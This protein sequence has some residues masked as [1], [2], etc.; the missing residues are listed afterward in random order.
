MEYVRALSVHFAAL[1]LL[2]MG[3]MGSIS[4]AFGNISFETERSFFSIE[5]VRVGRIRNGF[6]AILSLVAGGAIMAL[7]VREFRP[8]SYALLGSGSLMLVA[9]VVL[10]FKATLRSVEAME[11]VAGKGAIWLVNGIILGLLLMAVF[12]VGQYL[13]R[14][15][16]GGYWQRHVFSSVT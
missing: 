6:L 4:A 8:P 3:V 15:F 11:S 9:L 7:A 13:W 1:F 2:F 5:A 14:A 16:V 10:M 12:Y